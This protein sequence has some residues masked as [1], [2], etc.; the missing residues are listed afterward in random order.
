[1]STTPSRC[2]R[3]SASP[4]SRP[5]SLPCNHD[6]CLT[7]AAR[8]LAVAPKCPRCGKPAPTARPAT[9]GSAPLSVTVRHRGV[10]FHFEL[11]DGER[12]YPVCSSIWPDMRLK[13]VANGKV[14]GSTVTANAVHESVIQLIASRHEPSSLLPPWVRLQVEEWG[15]Y[16]LPRIRRM[17]GAVKMARPRELATILLN[18]VLGFG[19]ATRFFFLSLVVP[20]P[21]PEPREGPR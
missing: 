7:C 3:C 10:A 8:A 9:P 6:L 12:V 15:D 1:M 18:W 19:H 13:L 11:S 14:L 16:L 5:Y 2:G 20:P 21:R 4:P 17:I